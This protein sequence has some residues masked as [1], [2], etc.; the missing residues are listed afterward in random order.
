MHYRDQILDKI[1]NDMRD[2]CWNVYYWEFTLKHKGK[3]VVRKYHIL[4]RGSVVD[5]VVELTKLQHKMDDFKNR[6]KK[7]INNR[8]TDEVKLESCLNLDDD[9]KFVDTLLHFF[10]GFSSIF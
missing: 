2:F 1:Y 10:D 7:M 3:D 8:S 4:L 5:I 9:L 6:L